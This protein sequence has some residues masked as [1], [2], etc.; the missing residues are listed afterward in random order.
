MRKWGLVTT[1]FYA[2]IV[3]V[4]LSPA[5][6]F[7]AEGK[8]SRFLQDIGSL[9]RE[10][11]LWVFAG[12]LISGEALLLFLSVDVSHKRLKPRAHLLVSCLLAA[13]LVAL[14][15]ST[16]IC[17]LGAAIRGDSFELPVFGENVWVLWGSLWLLWGI[18]FYLYLQNSSDYVTRL[19]SWLLKGSVLELLVAV[20][21]HVVVRRRHEC[22]API[23][24]SWGIATGFAIMLMSF[25]P[26][27]LLLFKKRLDSYAARS[28]AARA[29]S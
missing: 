18:V 3:L 22:S 4:L 2:L 26:S 1:V 25:G 6:V 8:E 23:V 13:M 20:P 19:V 12:M 17:S 21:C 5:A 10:W 14:L 9:Y 29:S 24:T 11:R 27:V 28:K 15:T 7:L 16:V